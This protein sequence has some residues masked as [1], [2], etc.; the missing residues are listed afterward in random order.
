MTKIII[1]TS[2]KLTRFDTK[3]NGISFKWPKNCKASTNL[4]N[5]NHASHICD[6]YKSTNVEAKAKNQFELH[7]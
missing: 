4:R 1:T 2:P 6:G 3:A 7:K 5:K